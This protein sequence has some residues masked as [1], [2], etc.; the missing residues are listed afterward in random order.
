[1]FTLPGSPFSVRVLSA[2][3]G[4]LFVCSV[5]V[6]LSAAG[7]DSR[8]IEAVKASDAAAVQK[9]LRAGVPVNEP[10]A[11][12]MTALH[13][14]VRQDDEAMV[15]SLMS[16]GAK[17]SA[18]TRYG[19][20]PLALAAVNGNP[21]TTQMLLAAGANANAA[22]PEGETVLMAAARTG[23]PD[24][25]ERL[26]AAGARVDDE[27]KWRGETAL[28]WAAGEN[29]AAAV[30]VLLARGAKIN[31]QSKQI[32]Y[33]EMRLNLSFMATTELPRGGFSPVMFAAREGAFDAARVLADAK[34]NLNLQDPEGTTALMLAIMNVHYDVAV[35]L[36]E[37]GANPNVTD[38]AAMAAL[39]AVVDM[40]TM[41][42]LTNL[43][44][45]RPSGNV[46]SLD[47]LRRAPQAWRGCE[48]R[49]QDADAAAPPQHGRRFN[50]R[51]HDAVDAC[52]PVWRRCRHEG[53]DRGRC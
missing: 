34:A 31:A 32:D 17:A 8:L 33:P 6:V 19:V 39:Y 38:R 11:D 48:R 20:T 47:V 40:R 10:E 15:R 21:R 36:L 14:A 35:M 41:R 46:D 2:V 30:K 13:W 24:V 53:V 45:R 18:A 29:N 22:T 4:S 7:V 42:P 12:G 3:V 28:M 44:P 37:K 27:E 25:I 9:L 50:G 51:G 43:P 23:N 52:G 16:A 49:P 1:M 5:F 26:I